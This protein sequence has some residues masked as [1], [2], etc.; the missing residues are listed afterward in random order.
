MKV[1]FTAD[2]HIKV[3]QRNVPKEWQKQRYRELF[4]YIR[5]ISEQVDLVILG[6]D[7]F[8]S[9]PNT[10]EIALYVDLISDIRC[11]CIIFDGN[12]EASKKGETWLKDLTGLSVLVNDKVKVIDC[13]DTMYGIQFLPYCRLKKELK[14][15]KPESNILVTHVRGAIEPY[16]KPEVDLEL[17][18]KWDIVFAGDLHA[19]S[20]SQRNIVYPGS[21]LTTSFHRKHVDTGVIIFDTENPKDYEFRVLELPQLIRKTVESE[22]E[23]QPSLYDH[24]IYELKGSSVDIASTSDNSLLDKKIITKQNEAVLDL[25]SSKSREDE[26]S[27]YC[28]EILNLGDDEIKDIITMYLE[29]SPHD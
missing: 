14:T 7:I 5:D 24:T 2:L 8:D 27:T 12:H 15:L 26:I 25:S 3:G 11:P 17:F 13:T 6:G 23:I 10:E 21:P 28:S 18:D 20:N 4:D 29:G 16:V 22:D 1:L 9:R 19:H